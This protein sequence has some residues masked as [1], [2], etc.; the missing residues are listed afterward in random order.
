MMVGIDENVYM[1]LV[2][3]CGERMAHTGRDCTMTDMA[4][5]AVKDYTKRLSE[6]EV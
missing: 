6:K 2:K 3:A 1:L 5:E 4:T